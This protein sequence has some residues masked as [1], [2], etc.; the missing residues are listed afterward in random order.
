MMPMSCDILKIEN[1]LT[2]GTIILI[3]GRTSNARYLKN[4]FKRNWREYFDSISDQTIFLLDE[5]PLGRFNKEQIKFY[6]TI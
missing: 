6:N 4:N 5:K 3:D 1:Y 2:P